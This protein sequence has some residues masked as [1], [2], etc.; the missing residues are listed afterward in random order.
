MGAMNKSGARKTAQMLAQ[1]P[2]MLRGL[3]QQLAQRLSVAL[4]RIRILII[5]LEITWTLIVIAFIYYVWEV[6]L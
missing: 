2:K 1:D 4:R 6:V 5:A 3:V